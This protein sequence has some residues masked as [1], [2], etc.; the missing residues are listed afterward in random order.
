MEQAA[1]E[2]SSFAE[3]PRVNGT[4]TAQSSPGAPS[5]PA[6]LSPVDRPQR[7]FSWQEAR[8]AHFQ[9]RFIPIFKKSFIFPAVDLDLSFFGALS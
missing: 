8:Q 3:D 1:F 7:H 9:K 2:G 4:L 5:C 6:G